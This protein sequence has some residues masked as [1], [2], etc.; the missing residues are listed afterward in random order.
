MRLW[1]SRNYCEVATHPLTGQNRITLS[2]KIINN[3][4]NIAFLVTGAGK[5]EKVKEI[6]Q[7]KGDYKNFPASR[8]SPRSGKLFWF[9]DREAARGII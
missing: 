7:Q 5:A 3:S 4:A 1:D 2:G 6:L 9:L 8:V